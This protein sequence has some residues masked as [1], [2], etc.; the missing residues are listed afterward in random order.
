MKFREHRGLLSD[1]LA[2][3]VQIESREALDAYLVLLGHRGK[4]DV[5]YYGKDAR[6]DQETYIVTVDGNAVGFTDGDK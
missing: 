1:S 3:E 2:T 5:K 6:I 4:V